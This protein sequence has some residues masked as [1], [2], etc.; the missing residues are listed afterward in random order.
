MARGGATTFLT[1]QR[2]CATGTDHYPYENSE[3][4][5]KETVNER[6][7]RERRAVAACGECAIKDMCLK[8]AIDS[9]QE[10]GVWGGKTEEEVQ[11][12]IAIK[13]TSADPLRLA[14]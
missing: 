4:L 11:V 6:E 3:K 5:F 8:L 13:N 12:L 1:E 9:G 14:S 7:A 10:L 2:A